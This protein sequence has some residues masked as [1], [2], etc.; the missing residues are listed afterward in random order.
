MS[1]QRHTQKQGYRRRHHHQEYARIN[2]VEAGRWRRA[3]TK[4]KPNTTTTKILCMFLG[5][6]I[7]FAYFFNY[8]MCAIYSKEKRTMRLD[9]VFFMRDCFQLMRIYMYIRHNNADLE[10][11]DKIFRSSLDVCVI[12]KI[13]VFYFQMHAFHMT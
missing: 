12:N 9:A 2:Y 1:R 7:A 6:R 10:L 4:K 13:V 3:H 5:H 11:Y 8:W